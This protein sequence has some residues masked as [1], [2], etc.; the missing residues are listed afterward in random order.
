MDDAMLEREKDYWLDYVR[1]HV[2]AA[3]PGI[4][5]IMLR[6]KEE[7]GLLCVVSHSMRTNILRD[8]RANGLPEPDLVY[9]WELPPEHRKPDPWALF[10]I[11]ETFGL[12]PE[13][14]LVI[15]DLKPGFDMAV[16]CGAD[17]AAAGWSYDI[18]FIED[19]MRTNC[20]N[21]FKTVAE[22]DCFLL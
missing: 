4:R 18:A 19:F 17:F 8:F 20:R 6:Q 7:G 16:R 10:Q 2:P 9:G 11:R 21:Y 15:D 14:I 22:L 3:Y 5:E 13:E 12:A 1:G